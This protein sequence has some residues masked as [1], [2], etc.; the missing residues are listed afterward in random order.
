MDRP[1]DRTEKFGLDM[2]RLLQKFSGNM[3]RVLMLVLADLTWSGLILLGVLWGYRTFLH[4]DF[5]LVPFRDFWVVPSMIVIINAISRGYHGSVLNPGAV[6]NRI[7]EIRRL[8]LATVASYALGL[9]FL[10]LTEREKDYPWLALAIAMLLTGGGVP[11]ARFAIR[12]FMKM[13]GIGQIRVLIAGAGHTAEIISEELAATCYY[14]YEVIGYLD[15]D[16]EKRNVEICGKKWLGRLGDASRV[17]KLHNVSYI[18]CCLPPATLPQVLKDY[19]RSFSHVL[20]IPTNEV[21]PITAI[22][23]VLIGFISGFEFQNRVLFLLPRITKS[24]AEITGALFAV[25]LLLPLFC[26][27]ALLVKISSPGPV[28]YAARRLGRNGKEIR[29]LKFRSMYR[30]AEARLESMLEENPALKAEWTKNFKLK[31][32]PRVTPVGDFLR[33]ASLDELPQFINVLRGDMALIGPRPI[34][35]DEVNYYG[36]NYDVFKRVKPGITGLW[37]VSGRSDIDYDQRVA[38]DMFYVMNWSLWL[39]YYI[40]LKTF[41]VVLFRKGAH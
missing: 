32:D 3:L 23:P 9:L 24:L 15:D 39:D 27:L 26:I 5:S 8:F 37:Q 10:F 30:D 1:G 36:E 31:N 19:S 18:I 38:L 29:V 12:R 35:T 22:Y 17:G 41:Y 25:I 33:R 20:V 21:L 2:G 11:V 28:F 7:E 40:F 16:P 34:V 4:V 13:L 6:L 14:G